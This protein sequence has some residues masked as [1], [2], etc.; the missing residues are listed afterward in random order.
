LLSRSAACH[1]L[2]LQG[3]RPE[4]WRR[5]VDPRELIELLMPVLK[6]APLSRFLRL[7]TA[8]AGDQVFNPWTELDI[9]T[10]LDQSAVSARRR[11][12][13]LHLA[14][15]ARL[16][17]IGEA[18]GYQGCHV[19]GIPFTSER[20]IMAGKIPR[21]SSDGLR[22]SRRRIPWSEPSAT[23]IWSSLH[24]FGIAPQTILWNAFPW[25]PH[26]A[27]CLQSNRTPKP[28]ER[29]LGLAV[30]EALLEAFP[31]ASVG[32]VGRHAAKSLA[33]CGRTAFAL[34]HP[35]MGGVTAFR[36]GLRRFITNIL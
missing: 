16:L 12:L 34:R 27:G 11:R 20:L 6:T 36:R 13:Q 3:G 14:I 22:L 32:A 23:T 1:D 8:F 24:E 28:A 25:H 33:D 31:R 17:L 30:L 35:S 29:A 4:R 15:D 5:D 21:V 2:A 10:D 26:R 18:A 7:L 19:T 9:G